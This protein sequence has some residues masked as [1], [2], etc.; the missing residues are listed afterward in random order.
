[1]LSS[2]LLFLSTGFVIAVC[3]YS[4]FLYKCAYLNAFFGG[5]DY[6]CFAKTGVELGQLLEEEKLGGIPVLVFAN[7]QD[8]LSALSSDEVCGCSSVFGSSRARGSKGLAS[9]LMCMLHCSVRD[10]QGH[11]HR[12]P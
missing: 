2:V 12:T 6:C 11:F 10:I 9:A 5:G 3:C 7:K 4:P 8:L 1:M